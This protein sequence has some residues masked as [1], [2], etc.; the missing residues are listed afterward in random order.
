MSALVPE[1]LVHAHAKRLRLPV[2]ANQA[3]RFATEAATAG[4]EPLEFLAAL[5]SA[6]VAGRDASVERT[7]IAAAS[8]S[9][10]SCRGSTSAPCR[11]STRRSWPSSPGVPT[12]P[13][14]R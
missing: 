4:H 14:A 13:V 8:P 5:L 12:S 3:V 6:E 1:L 2:M 7:R 11:R 9:S 10:T